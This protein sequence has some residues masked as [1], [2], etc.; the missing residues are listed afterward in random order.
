M[1]LTGG[2]WENLECLW[3]EGTDLPTPEIKWRKCN[4]HRSLASFPQLPCSMPQPQP[5]THSGPICPV[6]WLHTSMRAGMAEGGAQGGDRWS[7]LGPGMASERGRDSHYWCWERGP[8]LWGQD[9]HCPYTKCSPQPLLA[10]ALLL[11]G[12][13]A[14]ARRQE[15]THLDGTESSLTR[16]SGLPFQQLRTWATPQWARLV[17]D[18]RRSTGTNAWLVWLWPI[19]VK[20]HLLPR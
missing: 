3:R 16:P 14:D 5:S 18:Q 13:G 11:W 7:W 20:S 19:H 17:T 4:L 12:K 6:A 9:W 10:P 1:V 15:D 2:L 8:G